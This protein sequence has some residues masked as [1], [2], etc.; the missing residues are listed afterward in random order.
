MS[1]PDTFHISRRM[2]LL[3]SLQVLEW[4]S[5]SVPEI[6]KMSNKKG[7]KFGNKAIRG[8]ILAACVGCLIIASIFLMRGVTPQQH[9]SSTITTAPTSSSHTIP[10]GSTTDL[11]TQQTSQS[12]PSGQTYDSQS[13]KCGGSSQS[14]TPEFPL[15][16][17][18]SVL[19]PIFGLTAY[20]LTRTRWSSN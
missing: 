5:G 20:A 8:S 14:I 13:G 6:H 10:T 3:S 4:K 18:M 15:G 2:N 19:V 12:C 16:A 1:G 7:K 17:L 9:P 11:T